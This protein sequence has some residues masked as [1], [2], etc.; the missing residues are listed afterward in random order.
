MF[1]IIIDNFN[2]NLPVAILDKLYY[3]QKYIMLRNIHYK[4]PIE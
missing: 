2:N 3:H 1:N 4:K